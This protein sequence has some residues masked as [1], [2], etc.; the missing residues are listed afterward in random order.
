MPETVVLNGI[1]S[2]RRHN[3]DEHGLGPFS[4]EACEEFLYF[5][6][7]QRDDS[8]SDP[9]VSPK[10]KQQHFVVNNLP[11][12]SSSIVKEPPVDPPTSTGECV[13][14]LN[15]MPKMIQSLIEVIYFNFI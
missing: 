13:W 12:A 15:A 10:A 5:P 3:H 8:P 4:G 7:L 2:F 1:R 14:D 11:S 6:S 9:S